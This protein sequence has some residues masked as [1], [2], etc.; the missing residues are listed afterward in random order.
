M[1]A[2][3]GPRLVQFAHGTFV[4]RAYS[5]VDSVRSENPKSADCIRPIVVS[6]STKLTTLAH[7]LV[8]IRRGTSVGSTQMIR[9]TSSKETG[10]TKMILRR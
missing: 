3:V 4:L 7:M 9:V 1:P 6:F 5:S 2:R 8:V 10:G